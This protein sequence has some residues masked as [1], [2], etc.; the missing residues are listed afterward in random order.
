MEPEPSIDERLIQECSKEEVAAALRDLA[1]R[2]E[3]GRVEVDSFYEGRGV[4]GVEVVVIFTGSR[5]F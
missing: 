2:L 5:K 3:S 1:D 4:T